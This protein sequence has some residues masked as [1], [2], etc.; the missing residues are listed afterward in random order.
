MI[1][2]PSAGG[3]R[4]A[5]RAVV[6]PDFSK[7]GEVERQPMRAHP[8]QD[9]RAHGGL[10]DAVPHVT[11]H[12]KAD[13]TDLEALRQKFGKALEAQASGKLTVTAVALKVVGR[14]AARRSRSSTP[15]IDMAGEA[16][17][18]KQYVH[19]GVAV[20]TE[21]GLLVPVIRDV[22]KKSILELAVELAQLAEKAR[23]RQALA[24]RD[25]GRLLHHHQPGRHRRHGV[26]ADRQPARG[27]DPRHV[28]RRG[29]S[30]SGRT[31]SS[32]RG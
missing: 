7:W 3:G 31:G 26:H 28:A 17:I 19:I 16:V 1:T 14:G 30:R 21:R 5:A 32:C 12:E 20:D 23:D 10:V 22:D 9:R 27:G 13:I 11:Q 18:L 4:Y 15:S 25:A 2:S 6:L 29:W 24:R 8:P